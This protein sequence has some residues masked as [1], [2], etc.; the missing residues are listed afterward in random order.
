MKR[1]A[2]L[3]SLLGWLLFA[4]SVH[5][6]RSGQDASGLEISNSAFSPA[7]TSG[8]SVVLNRDAD[9]G[10]FYWLHAVSYTRLHR[11]TGVGED[12]QWR[13]DPASSGIVEFLYLGSI[14]QS[15]S[16]AVNA[17]TDSIT[18]AV[19]QYSAAPHTCPS[20]FPHQCKRLQLAI[21]ST[22]TTMASTQWHDVFALGACLVE[23]SADRPNAFRATPHVTDRTLKIL[24]AVDRAALHAAQKT[25]QPSQKS[26][27]FGFSLTRVAILDGQGHVRSSFKVNQ[28]FVISIS[29]KVQHL[30]GTATATITFL[31]QAANGPRSKT[32]ASGRERIVTTNGL[33]PYQKET[34]FT[35]A[36]RYRVAVIVT[37]KSLSKR[38]AAMVTI[39]R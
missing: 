7:T 35:T 28:P 29:W 19:S 23:V 37:I 9:R 12:A 39:M 4:G 31:Y 38:G 30:K 36:G 25:C 17:Y 34:Q 2:L 22:P 11:V 10:Y 6:E 21:K 1:P 15:S 27:R 16:D 32:A 3:L 5:A 33:N 18:Y 24:D 20:G 14:F 26:G 13:P 8:P